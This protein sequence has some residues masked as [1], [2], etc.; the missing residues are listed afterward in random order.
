MVVS[1][2]VETHPRFVARFYM[3]ISSTV[4]SFAASRVIW[5]K[6]AGVLHTCAART[7][8]RIAEL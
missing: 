8:R 7:F 3:V 6:D 5:G 4:I 2:M 1:I